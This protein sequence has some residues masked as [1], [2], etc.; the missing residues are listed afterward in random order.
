MTGDREGQITGFYENVYCRVAPQQ[1]SAERLEAELDLIVRALDLPS[2]ARL[3]DLGCGYGRHAIPLTQRGYAVTAMDLSRASLAVARRSAREAGVRVRWLRRDM[4]D[5]PFTDYFHAVIC[6]GAFGA[7]DNDQEDLKVLLAVQAA[8]Q[9]GGRFV[10][11]HKSREW[12]LRHPQPGGRLELPDGAVSEWSTEIDLVGGYRWDYE[13][14]LE[15]DGT[16]REY[17]V[18]E[19]LY[20]LE[21]LSAMIAATGLSVRDVW[22]DYGG[23]DY[24][25]DSLRMIVLAEKA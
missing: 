17:K 15:A 20:T 6:M 21:E 4:R 24:G 18:R 13:V 9:P 2:G 10:L 16:R 19:R 3:L 14:F 12:Q 8:L 23:R 5:I 22:G 11:D 7:L 1:L 25:V